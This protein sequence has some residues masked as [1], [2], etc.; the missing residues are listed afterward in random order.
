MNKKLI[1]IGLIGLFVSSCSRPENNQTKSTYTFTLNW[2]ENFNQPVH[3]DTTRW[4]KTSRGGSDWNDTMSDLD[5]LYAMHNGKLIL[6]GIQNTALK[7]D[8]S[9]YL[10][11]GVTTKDKVSFGLGRLEIRAKLGAA[12]GAWPA[13]WLLG[14]GVPYP[15][16]GEIDIMEHLNHDN[17]VYQTVHSYYT[18]T[19]GMDHP[20]HSSTAP[21]N[22]NE[23]NTYAVEMYQDSVVFYVNGKRNFSYSRI[24]TD[25]KEQFPF[26]D[27]PHY[28][29]LSMQLGGSWVGKV[30][31]EE[32]PVKMAI[33][34]IQ[35]Y[36]LDKREK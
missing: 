25:K 33:D 36:S 30:D 11:G 34:W 35:F 2:E 32:L 15:D 9:K 18:I 8:T 20:D 26:A 7:E 1:L 29:I 23:F 3:F 17:I 6:R 14:Q 27:V 13:F 5:T 24:K 28:L 31:P 22:P 12:T 19:L 21:I 4:S 10:T 16:G